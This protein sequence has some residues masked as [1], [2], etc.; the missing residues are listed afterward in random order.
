MRLDRS[1][2]VGWLLMTTTTAATA[3]THHFRTLLMHR[4]SESACDR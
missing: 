4:F 3:A 1:V 2:S